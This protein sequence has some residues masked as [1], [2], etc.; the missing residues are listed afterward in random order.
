MFG[1]AAD[2]KT[3]AEGMPNPFQLAVIMNRQ[4]DLVRLPFPP[5][6]MQRTGLALGRRSEGSWGTSQPTSLSTRAS[7]SPNRWRWPLRPA[8]P[9]TLRSTAR[10]GP[11]HSSDLS[12][13]SVA[14]TT[15]GC[16]CRLRSGSSI[17]CLPS[18]LAVRRPFGRRCRY[19]ISKLAK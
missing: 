16:R 15:A 2:G 19:E 11:R 18:C 5:A 4:F 8:R 3:N 9:H 12:V 13:A 1:L 17:F 7:R 10:H 6:W 14:V